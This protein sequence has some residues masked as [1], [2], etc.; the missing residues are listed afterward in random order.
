[1]SLTHASP[2]IFCGSVTPDRAH[3]P[4]Q[5]MIALADTGRCRIGWLIAAIGHRWEMR[6][7]E[8]FSDHAL[9]DIGFE[10]DWDGTV[11]ERQK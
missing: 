3:R 1:M 4:L 11:I 10:R 9:Q 6:R 8:R 2:D 7:L 5:T